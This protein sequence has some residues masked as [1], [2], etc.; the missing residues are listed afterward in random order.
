[1]SDSIFDVIDRRFMSGNSVCVERVHIKSDE[2]TDL[3]YEL[4][5]AREENERLRKAN[6][7]CVAWGKACKADL[8]RAL[9]RV[10]ELS[11]AL[12]ATR[13]NMADWA[14]YVDAYFLD[15]HDFDGDMDLAAKAL[16]GNGKA[17]LLRK[18]ADAVKKFWRK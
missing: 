4:F 10:A 11:E 15:K 7:D 5:A 13:A 18:Q 1:M 2:W 6:Q 17:W 8:D 12:E 3:K 9:A 16:A 14:S